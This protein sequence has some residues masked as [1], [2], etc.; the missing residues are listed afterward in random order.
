MT[1]GEDVSGAVSVALT[2]VSLERMSAGSS[3]RRVRFWGDESGI[4]EMNGA[5]VQQA[6]RL[7]M[8]PAWP[9]RPSASARAVERPANAT[10]TELG[11]NNRECATVLAIADEPGKIRAVMH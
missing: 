11:M 3:M 8:V 7:S 1:S 9:L 2:A 10:G 5:V 4:G 6:R